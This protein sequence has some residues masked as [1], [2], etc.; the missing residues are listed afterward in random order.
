MTSRERLL[1]AIRHEEPDRV[2]ISPRIGFWLME[3]YGDASLETQLRCAEEFDWDVMAVCGSDTANYL[4]GYPDE[5]DLPGVQVEQRQHAD[6]NYIVIERIF[7]TPAGDLRDVTRIPPSRSHYGMSPN[8]IKTEHLLKGPDDL[9]A[10]AHICPPPGTNY[11]T[12]HEADRLIGDRGLASVSILSPLDHQAGD[13]R[14]MQDLMVDYYDNRPF[15]DAQLDFFRQRSLTTLRNALEAGV[16]VIFGSWYF[17]SLSAGWS[18]RIFREVFL[19]A[20]KEQVDLTH[21][22]GAIY[23]YYDDGKCA[24]ILGMVKEAGVDVFET[25]TPPPVGD[26]D[27][28]TAKQQIG[29]TVCLK[30]W[31]DLLYVVKHG[32]PELIDRTVEEGIE[33]A[34]PGGGFILG[35]SDSFRDGT[36]LENIR[37]YFAAAHRYGARR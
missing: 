32:T 8:P 16:E 14:G 22:Y 27:L 30:G 26:F 10:L 37:A 5:Y 13:A 1:T 15:F 23:D 35:S 20:I 34:A 21:S 17:H 33:I 25:C 29:D 7:R 9:T 4:V 19:P 28:T 24:A 3:H 11:D 12:Y 36:P 18:P 31:T 6:G 2:P